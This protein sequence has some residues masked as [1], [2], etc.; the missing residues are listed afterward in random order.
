MEDNLFNT[1][2]K[3]A[4]AITAFTSLKRSEGWQLIS[5]I[6]EENINVL[7]FQLNNGSK[8]ETIDD[9]NRIRDKIKIYQDL[10]KEPDRLINLFSKAET[11]AVVFDPYYNSLDEIKKEIKEKAK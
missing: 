3:R 4:K 8:G 10:V 1:S 11:D 2:E 7:K 6:I 9:I 5:S